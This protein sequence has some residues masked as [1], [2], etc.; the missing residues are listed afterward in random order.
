M[1][2]SS[3][4]VADTP[5]DL[6]NKAEQLIRGG[7]KEGAFAI[8]L[9]AE[10]AGP[11]SPQSEDRIGFLYAVLGR[12]PEAVRHFE[13]SIALDTSYAAGHYHLGVALWQANDH[14]HG[15]QELEAAAKL[16]PNV[17][18][19]RYRLGSAYLLLGKPD[20]AAAE[21]KQ[22]VGLDGTKI[23]A[24]Q[25]L[26]RALQGTGDLAGAVDANE[27]ALAFDPANDSLRDNYAYLLI[28]T[29]RAEQG[30]EESR[31]VLAHNPADLSALMNIGYARL[32]TG[33]F[34]AAEQ[35][36]RQAVAADG[37]SAVAHYDLGIALKMRD[38]L[39]AAQT[40]FKEAIRLE[41]RLAE[42]HYSLGIADWQLGDFA[43]MSEQM[44]AALGIR[45]EYAEAHYMLGI[46]LKQ[47]RD[48]DGATVELKEAI[49]LDPSTP[50]PYNTLGQILRIKGDKTVSD[51]MFATGARLK[52]EKESQL[53]NTLDQG[54]RGGSVMKP[55]GG[56]PQ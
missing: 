40:E 16:A 24:W 41:P 52:R 4:L 22:A 49:R 18:D 21:L 36:Y 28:E 5:Q 14:E 34:D 9:E 30:I 10:R 47:G 33:A 31:K 1:W 45:P 2:A 38:Q 51:Q 20:E 56:G 11:A 43:G 27:H 8:L 6:A 12:G 50:G 39:E 13:K 3:P 19:Y 46:A 7:D 35:A 32:M 42:A 15:V 17:F 44:R 53:A 25:D 37:Q 55:L 54:M 23:A 48:L 29:R 26:G